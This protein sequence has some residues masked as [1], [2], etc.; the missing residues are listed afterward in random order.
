MLGDVLRRSGDN[1][2][3]KEFAHCSLDVVLGSTD[4]A[5]RCDGPVAVQDMVG[6]DLHLLPL[7]QVLAV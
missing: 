1:P 6:R 3:S 5:G 2:R 4:S 7:R